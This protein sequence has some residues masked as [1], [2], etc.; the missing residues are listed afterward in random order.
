M[1]DNGFSKEKLAPVIFAL[2]GFM[3]VAFVMIFLPAREAR[4][5]SAEGLVIRVDWE[6]PGKNYP[7]IKIRESDG[8]KKD[9]T[10]KSIILT[11]DD[12]GSGDRFKKESGSKY[13][14]INEVEIQCLD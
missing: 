9:F 3:V 2:L 13:C 12:I 6:A 10:A 11:R 14:L 8:T 1:S 5:F 7:L 4:Q